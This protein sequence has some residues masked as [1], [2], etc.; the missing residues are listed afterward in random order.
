MFRYEGAWAPVG[1]YGRV[2]VWSTEFLFRYP[3]AQSTKG[4]VL[5]RRQTKELWREMCVCVCV[6]YFLFCQRAQRTPDVLP[7]FST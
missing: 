3:L 7:G 2:E 4:L 1:W 6:F 5:K